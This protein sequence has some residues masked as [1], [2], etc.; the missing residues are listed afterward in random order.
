M[1]HFRLVC[2]N[3][4]QKKDYQV[5]IQEAQE[6]LKENR[7]AVAEQGAGLGIQWELVRALEMQA[8]REETGE[9]DKNKL[10]NQ[11]LTIARVI[12]RFPGEYKDGSRSMIERLNVELNRDPGDPKDFATAFG[13]ARNL[14]FDIPKKKAAIEQ[15]SG[16]ERAKLIS[17]LQPHPQRSPPV[18]CTSACRWP[19]PRT[20]RRTSTR[21]G[22]FWRTSTSRCAT[23]DIDRSYDAAVLAEYVSRKAMKS[24]P[25]LALEAAYLAQAAYIQAYHN[26]PKDNPQ[27]AEIKQA[28]DFKRIIAVCNFI[29]DNWPTSDKAN[30]ARMDAGPRLQR[31]RPARQGRRM[32]A[33]GS[34]NG[35]TVLRSSARG[36]ERLLVRV[37]HRI[38]QARGRAETQ[39]RTGR[40]AQAGAGDPAKRDRE[41]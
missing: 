12:N 33:A 30:D 8:K 10:L 32:V 16:A 40:P 23:S 24:Q 4:D 3:R 14:V 37:S 25:D 36:R 15:A 22:I 17:E 34:R 31:N 29:T 39:R 18:S 5:V 21:R 7:G 27:A 1:L 19:G 35:P 38:G 2:L 26:P 11:A 9:A 13:S 28:G 41:I 20:N 6:W